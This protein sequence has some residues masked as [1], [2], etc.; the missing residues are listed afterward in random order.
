MPNIIEEKINAL[1]KFESDYPKIVI[2]LVSQFAAEII[3]LNVDQ[4]NKGVNS[5]GQPIEPEYRP[6]TVRIKKEKGQPFNRVTLKDEGDFHDSFFLVINPTS[7]A[8]YATDEKT[9]KLERKYGKEIFGLTDENLQE[10]IDLL[11]PELQNHFKEL[12]C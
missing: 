1:K 2:K 5:L 8:I 4:L 7:I 9:A 3:D 6:F 12:V 11:K 10:I